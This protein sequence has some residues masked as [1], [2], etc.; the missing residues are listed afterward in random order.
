MDYDHELFKEIKPNHFKKAIQFHQENPKVYD[1][2]KR[3]ATEAKNG[4]RQ[5]FG[6]A[7]IWERM[8]WYVAFETNDKTYKLNN[9]HKAFYARMLMIDDSY[10]IGVFK[11]KV[12][13]K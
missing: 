13:N 4:N 5:R 3:F 8:R 9:N 7:M 2:V 11:R 6:I 1:L 10:F 12:T